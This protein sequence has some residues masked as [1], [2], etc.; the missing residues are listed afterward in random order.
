VEVA[1][2]AQEQLSKGNA[3]ILGVV[4]NRVKMNNKHYYG[5]YA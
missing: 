5:Y 4:M 1:R 2:Q 3:R